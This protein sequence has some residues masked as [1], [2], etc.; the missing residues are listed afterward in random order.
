MGAPSGDRI[1]LLTGAAVAL[2]L[3]FLTVLT[4]EAFRTDSGDAPRPGSGTGYSKIERDRDDLESRLGVYPPGKDDR[5]EL[6][7]FILEQPGNS[8]ARLALGDLH[9]QDGEL[10]LAAASYRRAV[11]LD[12]RYCDLKDPVYHGEEMNLLVENGLKV[13]RRERDLRPDDKAVLKAMKD[14]YFLKRSLAG[15]CD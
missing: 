9:R 12:R 14:L 5:E 10:A 7:G 15:G 2:L 8:A 3:I 13:F 4:V 11:E 6:E 1:T